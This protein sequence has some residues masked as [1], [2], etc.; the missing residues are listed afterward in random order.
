MSTRGNH[1]YTDTKDIATGNLTGWLLSPDVRDVS[2]ES[3]LR[4]RCGQRS[5]TSRPVDLATESR[6][7]APLLR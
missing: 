2:D 3:E 5:S 1:H 7:A 6:D 4:T